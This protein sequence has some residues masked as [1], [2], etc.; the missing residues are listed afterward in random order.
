[1]PY[2]HKFQKDRLKV[3]TEILEIS[4]AVR[5][6]KIML[7]SHM[8]LSDPLKPVICE[9][10]IK[11]KDLLQDFHTK[12]QN[13]ATIAVLSYARFCHKAEG[14]FQLNYIKCSK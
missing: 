14:Q 9:E 10:N 4:Q 12:H 1:M 5:P 11:G 13:N 7:L 3:I 6:L 2:P 8:Y